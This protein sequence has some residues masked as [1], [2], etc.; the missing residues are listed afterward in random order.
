MDAEE[1]RHEDE[2]GT[3]DSLALDA[4]NSETGSPA[5][6][7]AN[8]DDGAL[9]PLQGRSDPLYPSNASEAELTI[10]ERINEYCNRHRM[11]IPGRLRLFRQVC[12]TVHSAH[13]HALIHGNLKP[14]SILVAPDG[15]PRITGFRDPEQIGVTFQNNAVF[16]GQE[17]LDGTGPPA[18]SSTYVSPEQVMGDT[19]TTASDIYS[20]GVILYELATGRCPYHL[21]T[22]DACE[23]SQAICDQ[24]PEKPS[25][26]VIRPMQNSAGLC[27]Y[28]AAGSIIEPESPLAASPPGSTADPRLTMRA[29]AAARGCSPKQLQNTLR[30]D[31]DAII[32]QAMRKEPERRYSS[33]DHL[34]D[35]LSCLLNGFPVRAR[36]GS[37]MYQTVKLMR[38]HRAAAISSAVLILTLIACVVG[39]IAGLVII[40]R[41]RNQTEASYRQARETVNQLFNQVS[42]ERLLNQPRLHPLRKALL[43]NVKSFYEEFLKRHGGDRSLRME[44]AEAHA[45]IAQICGTIG[46]TTEALMHYQQAV[47]LWSSLVADQPD[48]SIYCEALARALN[49]QGVV[50]MRLPEQRDEAAQSLR[51]AQ[52]LVEPLAAHSRSATAE[53]ELA[54]VL[55]HIALFE[56]EQGRSKEAIENTLRSLAIE[57]AQA[58]KNP[59]AVDPVI[60]MA[61]GHAL[62]GQLLVTEPEGMES[63]LAEYQRAVELLEKLGR[64]HPELCDQAYELATLL[65]EESSLEQSSGKLDSALASLRKAVEI[66]EQLDRQYPDNL[67][68]EQGLAHTY[69]MISNLHRYRREP[70]EAIAFVQKAKGLLERRTRIHPDET[71]PR[72]VLASSQN[73]LGRLLEQTGEPVER[74]DRS[75]VPLTSMKAYRTLPPT[76]ATAWRV[77]LRSAS[78]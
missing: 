8:I 21:K 41:Q 32:L 56:R 23:L 34:A 2:T 48:N 13:Q 9:D 68:Y 37:L 18:L 14:E 54:L 19:V 47:A 12:A 50:M 7:G 61:R 77:T 78:L 5:G 57:A 3:I 11:D 49:N 35:D 43:G 74:S 42:R 51:R 65:G 10:G 15:V 46:S 20:L 29:N 6:T 53:G 16:Q 17:A 44:S 27:A 70:T 26:A 69:N 28:P 73:I 59:G 55:E 67:D 64:E 45:R 71:A 30:G 39:V 60:A 4:V 36:R 25:A 24:A 31:L 76:I 40:R 63:A 52:K 66:L 72:I 33:A 62:L 38:R 1:R 22:G 58:D 75:S